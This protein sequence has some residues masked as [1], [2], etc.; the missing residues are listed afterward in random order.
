MM[1]KVINPLEIYNAYLLSSLTEIGIAKA[2]NK[3]VEWVVACLRLGRRIANH[4][5]ALIISKDK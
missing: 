5:L 2:L 4:D 3:S 1:N